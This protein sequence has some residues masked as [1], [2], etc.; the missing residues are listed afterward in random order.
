MKL[1]FAK[2]EPG[3]MVA[4]TCRKPNRSNRAKRRCTRY[5]TIGSVALQGRR[6]P[7]TVSFAGML[8]R[9]KRL[10][11]GSYK[12]TATPTDAAHNTGRPRTAK[13]KIV[14]R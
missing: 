14:N 5:V 6:G 12:L 11:P 13:L 10:P 3:R 2:A 1:S 9:A 4:K 7:N 8:S